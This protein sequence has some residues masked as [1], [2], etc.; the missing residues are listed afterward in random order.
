[1]VWIRSP[2]PDPDFGSGLLPKVNGTSLSNDASVIKF[3]SKSDHTLRRYEPNC[4]KMPYLAM[5]KN[6]SKKFLDP[7]PEADDFQTLV[8]SFLCIVTSMV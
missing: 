2:Y 4:G 7:N 1:M 8:N 6:P 5:L 3:S